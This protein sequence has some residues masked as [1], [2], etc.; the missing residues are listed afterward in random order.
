MESYKGEIC[1]KNEQEKML[2]T[3]MLTSCG[4]G[5]SVNPITGGGYTIVVYTNEK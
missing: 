2:F 1:A 4:Y 5:V 3:M